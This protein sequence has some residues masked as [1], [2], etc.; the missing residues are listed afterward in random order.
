MSGKFSHKPRKRFGQNFLKDLNIVQKI[1]NILKLN[2]SDRVL[3]IGPGL[4]V[5]TRPILEAV[6]HLEVIEIDRDLAQQLKST[7][8][9]TYPFIIHTADVL[10]FD[11]SSLSRFEA[12]EL[13]LTDKKWRIIGNLPYNISTPLIF[14]LLKFL[15]MIEDMYFLL[16]KEVVDRLTATPYHKE[17]GRL[18]ILLQYYCD[19]RAL[20]TVEPTAFYPIPKVQS[21]F[22]RLVPYST[23]PFPPT[24]FSQLQEVTRTAFNQRRKTLS[25]ALKVYLSTQDFIALNI[26][27]TLRPEALSIEDFVRISNFIDDRSKYFSN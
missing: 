26:D 24:R 9:A 7:L 12:T 3:E 17:Y 8:G 20:F 6:N 10:H 5:L 11:F 15:P 13:E 18:S 2:R 21:T 22:V 16:Q 27:P 23:P 4:G 19:I 25:N 14:H 1:I